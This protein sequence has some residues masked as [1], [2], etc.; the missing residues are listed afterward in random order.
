MMKICAVFGCTNYAERDRLR[1]ISFHRLPTD[2]VTR[3]LWARSVGMDL[4]PSSMIC[5]VHFDPE[6]FY[7]KGNRS[8]LLLDS[9]PTLNMEFRPEKQDEH[10]YASRDIPRYAEICVQCNLYSTGLVS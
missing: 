9:V 10:G 4:P 1:G 3:H 8:H 2:P 6:C 5:A 7:I